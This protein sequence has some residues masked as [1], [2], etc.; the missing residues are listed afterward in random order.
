[1]ASN[2]G[3]LFEYNG[4]KLVGVSI[5]FLVLNPLFVGLRFY[6]R[7]TTKAK[8]GYDDYLTI[9]ALFA[10]MILDTTNISK[11]SRVS[12]TQYF[13][14]SNSTCIYWWCRIP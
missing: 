6:T 14:D 12:Y 13:S 3:N 2:E 9:P 10:N 7:R 4:N 8:V 5:A 1:M 11:L